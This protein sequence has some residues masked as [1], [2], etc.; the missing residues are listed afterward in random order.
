MVLGSPLFRKQLFIVELG[1]AV[2]LWQG[3][4]DGDCGAV[5][6]WPWFAL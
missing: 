4:N 2:L 6:P 3:Q 1:T 5:F